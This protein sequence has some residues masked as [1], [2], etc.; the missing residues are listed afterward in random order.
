MLDAYRDYWDVKV[1][2]LADPTVDPS[3]DLAQV[4]IDTAFT[5]VTSSV[6]LLRRDGI[7]VVGAP[8]LEPEVTDIEIGTE[9]TAT[10]IDC[11]D[12]TDWTPQFVESGES[13]QAPGVALRVVTT[14]TAVLYSGRWTIRTSVADRESAC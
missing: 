8:E 3:A 4:A 7:E 2:A 5:D 14:S 10:I 13:A 12:S 11:V 6:E 9:P 1:A